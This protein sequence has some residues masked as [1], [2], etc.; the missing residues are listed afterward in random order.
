MNIKHTIFFDVQE[1]YYL[2]QYLPV[3]KELKKHH[4]CA[5]T[6]IFHQNK[7]E[8][9]VKNIILKEQLPHHWVNNK[10]EALQFYLDKKPTI[11]EKILTVLVGYFIM[12]L[13]LSIPFYFSIYKL[14]F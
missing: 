2:P 7:F 10:N 6:F 13:V 1:L 9:I 14:T 12:P 8:G 5:I 11:F 4:N 3:F